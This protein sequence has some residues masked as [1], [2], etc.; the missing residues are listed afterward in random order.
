MLKF[1]AALSCVFAAV[2]AA[3]NPFNYRR[4]LSN[5][6]IDESTILL[7]DLNELQASILESMGFFMYQGTTLK[8]AAYS[9]PT[10]GYSWY[11]NDMMTGGVF[12]IAHEYI[13]DTPPEGEEF[14][15]GGGGYSYFTITP[16][17][18]AGDG[19]FSIDY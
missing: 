7:D 1:S 3:K 10:T 12:T 14:W 19:Y 4:L 17:E 13:A 9:N 6:A 5:A 18:T 8:F 11:V 2:E 16:G 15:S